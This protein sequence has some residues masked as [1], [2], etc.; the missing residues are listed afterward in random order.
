MR[1]EIIT[2][3]TELFLDRISNHNLAYL[4]NQFIQIGCLV[5]FHTTVPDDLSLIT[6]AIKTALKR[7][8][9]IIITG[10]LGPTEDDITRQTVAG[11]VHKNLYLNRQALQSIKRFFKQRGRHMLTNNEVQAYLPKGARPLINQC[12]TAPG[13]R[14]MCQSKTIIALP[15]VPQEL[16][17]NFKM[18]LCRV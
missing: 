10:G 18:K 16:R 2:T 11:A 7:V 5:N 14:I 9:L 17:V 12:G 13:F 4:S 3:G 8:D 1:V 6:Q 15:G